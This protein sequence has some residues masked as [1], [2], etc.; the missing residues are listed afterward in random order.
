MPDVDISP[1]Q[2]SYVTNG[3]YGEGTFSGMRNDTTGYAV[4]TTPDN[5]Y[6]C[7]G[8]LRGAIFGSPMYNHRNVLQDYDLSDIP[9]GSTITA[10]TFKVKGTTMTNLGGGMVTYTAQDCSAIILEGTFGSSIATGDIDSFTGYTS[11]WDASD[12]TEYT[13]NW[14]PTAGGWSTSG[15]NSI[16]LNA[17]GIAAANSALNGGTRLK[18]FIGEYESWYLNDDSFFDA[19]LK[20]SRMNGHYDL[21]NSDS[22]FITVTYTEGAIVTTG[23]VKLETGS[24]LQIVSGK[25]LIQ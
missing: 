14:G 3:Y 13:S 19:N 23:P 20:V 17:D 6:Y 25:F 5:V 15:F 18:F 21:G 8:V 16:S 2:S 24:K 11:G 22:P 4:D 1:E 12:V 10:V 9:A 7:P